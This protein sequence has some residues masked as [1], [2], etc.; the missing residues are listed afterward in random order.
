[1]KTSILV[2]A[3]LDGCLHKLPTSAQNM[4]QWL[5]AS[6]EGIELHSFKI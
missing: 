5:Q 3:L 4:I 1:M 6:Q 2:A